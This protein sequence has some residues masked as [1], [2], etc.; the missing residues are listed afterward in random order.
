MCKFKAIYGDKWISAF[1]NLVA[2]LRRNEVHCV[3]IYDTCAPIDK[4][5]ERADRAEKKENLQ[6]KVF[7]LQTAVEKYHSTNEIDPILVEFY[8]KKMKK[9]SPIK[10]LLSSKTAKDKDFAINIDQIE[11]WI[12]I[13]RRQILNITPQDFQLTKDLFTILNVPFFQAPT[14]AEKFCSD[15]CR[16]NIIDAVLSEDTDVLAYGA[17]V[18]LSK[19]DTVKETCIMVKHEDVLNSLEITYPQFLDLCIMCGCDYNKNIYK[20]GPEKAFK[21]I[22]KYGSIEEIGKNTSHD[23][24]VLR[25]ERVR[26]LFTKYE[27]TDINK[28]P[29][30]GQPES[31]ALIDFIK[32]NNIYTDYNHIEKSFIH[33]VI[34]FEDDEK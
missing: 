10:S 29:Y 20:V 8:N 31:K 17:P 15:L 27:N 5:E 19:I 2:C 33:N 21:Y 16:R 34:V 9:V 23:I 4:A 7:D 28:I 22:Q 18:F 1:L 6:K 25:Y 13:T 14:E 32:T 24:S 12:E 11:E 26:E 3:F 30:C